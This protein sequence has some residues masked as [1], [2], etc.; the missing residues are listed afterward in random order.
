MEDFGTGSEN[1]RTLAH[2]GMIGGQR[3]WS[4]CGIRTLRRS[5]GLALVSKLSATMTKYSTDES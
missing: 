2:C 3:I 4:L 1:A 5:H